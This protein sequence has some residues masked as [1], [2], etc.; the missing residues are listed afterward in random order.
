[1]EK[2]KIINLYE[3]YKNSP[4]KLKIVCGWDEVIQSHEPYALWKGLKEK[5]DDFISF[6]KKF[7]SKKTSE[8]TWYLDP[9]TGQ[10][11]EHEIK[12][13][14]KKAFYGNLEIDEYDCLMEYPPYSSRLKLDSRD[15]KLIYKIKASVKMNN[16]NNNQVPAL[17]IAKFFLSLDPERKYFVNKKMMEVEGESTPIIGNLRLNKLLQ[18]TQ[19]LYAAKEGKYLFSEKFLAFEH[20][21]IIYEVYHDFHFLVDPQNH[22]PIKGLS[23]SLKT[24]LNKIYNYFKTYSNQE[25]EYFVHEDPAWFNAWEKK[26]IK[27]SQTML[28]NSEMIK[29]YQKFAS[30]ILE[31]VENQEAS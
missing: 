14:Q 10:K 12:P 15:N 1:M 18:I 25:L 19:M 23:S 13:I 4:K 8:T 30:H 20:G 5:Q 3:H 26:N 22:A 28:Q 9:E 29:Y 21:G 31:S 11:I 2:N 27:K 6:F 7:W 16:E 24:F 17:E